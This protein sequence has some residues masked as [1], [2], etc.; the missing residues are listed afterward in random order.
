MAALIQPD[1]GQYIVEIDY[2]LLCK[3]IFLDFS[4]HRFFAQIGCGD[5]G[6]HFPVK[7]SFV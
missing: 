6:I 7:S 1:V 5:G 3:H 4:V 2:N